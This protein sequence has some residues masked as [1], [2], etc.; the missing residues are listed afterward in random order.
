[1]PLAAPPGP[2]WS[3][4]AKEPH[5]ETIQYGHATSRTEDSL[6]FSIWTL[7]CPHRPLLELIEAN[8]AIVEDDE[9]LGED[10][11]DHPLVRVER[12]VRQRPHAHALGGDGH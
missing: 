12:F 5:P 1:M 11:D 8:A 10:A 7:S 4:D 9:V 2:L 3:A 6:S